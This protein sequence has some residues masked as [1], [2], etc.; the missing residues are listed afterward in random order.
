ML[1]YGRL[2]TGLVVAAVLCGFASASEQEKSAGGAIARA[3]I[4]RDSLTLSDNL[5]LTV[6]V[7]GRSPLE[8]EP[9]KEI[10]PSPTWVVTPLAGPESTPLPD[11]RSRWQ[12]RYQ[13]SPL[14]NGEVVLP[15]EPLKFRT[16]GSEVMTVKW[17]DFKL[18]V[19]TVVSA[20]T[21]AALKDISPIERLPESARIPWGLALIAASV[22]VGLL[23]VGWG[24]WRASRKPATKPMDLPPGAWALQ[25]LA[26]IE[27]MNLPAAGEGDKFHTQLA[28]TL[29]TYLDRRF[30]VR[31]VE[32]TTA[33]V[34][35]ALAQ[36]NGVASERQETLRAFFERC[37]LAKFARAGYAPDECQES[38]RL[39]RLFVEGTPPKS[40]QPE[41][42]GEPGA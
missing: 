19:A 5:V 3:R 36:T 32:R 22:S 1:R 30:G 24:A 37:D 12:Q 15:L 25:E 28:D 26:R 29:R 10:T 40:S 9:I 39:A 20:P 18:T 11:R 8:I 42:I 4:D 31:T 34:L 13:I 17:D 27:A 38:L 33:E 14:Q 6:S 23:V 7:E 41:A 21:T 2:C 16:A 35:A